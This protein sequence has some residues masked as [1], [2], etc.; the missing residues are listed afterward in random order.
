MTKASGLAAEKG[1]LLPNTLDAIDTIMSDKTFGDA[2]DTCV[3]EECLEGK[4]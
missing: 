2:G 4:N 3:I 1:V